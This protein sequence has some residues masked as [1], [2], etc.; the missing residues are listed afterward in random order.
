MKPSLFSQ[1][2][3]ALDLFEAIRTASLAGYDAV[4]L[5]CWGRHLDADTARSSKEEVKNALDAA[6]LSVSALSLSNNFTA[7]DCL[8]V[9]L[10]MAAEFIRLAPF[11]G[12]DV[13]KLT[14]G[15]PASSDAQER[16][17]DCLRTAVDRLADLAEDVGVRL[18]F[19]THMRQLTDTLDSS[20]RFLE[21]TDRDCVGLTV[22]F[23]NLSFAGDSMED[24]VSVLSE[25]MYHTHV[26]NGYID[27]EGG[28][29]FLSLN[30]GM[31]DYPALL[32]MLVGANY[33][34]HLSVECLGRDATEKPLE[35]AQRDLTI[36]QEYLRQVREGD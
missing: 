32:G 6:G 17:W 23:L 29:H 14:P 15:P 30:E 11:L 22:D 35:T 33:D 16:H 27:Q 24:V 26:K 5:A 21:L 13:V 20:V 2:L 31:L 25:R 9:Q 36:L 18:A 10:D 28:W 8:G 3:S 4:E 7:P 1:S 34:G 19:E 12:T